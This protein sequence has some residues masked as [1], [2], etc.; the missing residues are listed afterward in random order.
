MVRMAMVFRLSHPLMAAAFWITPACAGSYDRKEESSANVVITLTVWK[1]IFHL[2]LL[3]WKNILS[4][5]PSVVCHFPTNILCAAISKLFTRLI[6]RLTIIGFGLG[7]V[8]YTIP[9]DSSLWTANL[10]PN[11]HE[12]KLVPSKRNPLYGGLPSCLGSPIFHFKKKRG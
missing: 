4:H 2:T 11:C 1:T 3:V 6:G 9:H 7:S 5:T 12:S 10:T 8:P